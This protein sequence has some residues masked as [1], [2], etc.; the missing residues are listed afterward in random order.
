MTGHRFSTRTAVGLA[1]SFV[2]I[3][4]FVATVGFAIGL[5]ADVFR[6]IAAVIMVAIGVVLMLPSF[7]ARLAA[8]SGPIAKWA[9]RRYGS[10]H[11]SGLTGQS[12]IGVL[13]GAV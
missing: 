9:D 11:G 2:A 1:I 12:W 10:D 7:Q 4:L 3:G 13:L 8:A 5:D 6:Y